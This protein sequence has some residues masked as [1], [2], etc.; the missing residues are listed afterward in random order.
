MNEIRPGLIIANPKYNINYS[1]I[2]MLGQGSFGEVWL[3]M[4]QDDK[5]HRIA[6][7]FFKPLQEGDK[8][9]FLTEY[10][11]SA[12]FRHDNVLPSLFYGEW[13][14]RLFMGMKLC[15]FGTAAQFI[16]KLYPNKKEDEALIWNFI[17]DTASGLEYLHERENVVHQDIK[18]DNVMINSNGDFVIMDFGISVSVN[19]D[20]QLSSYSAFGS[21]AYMAPERFTDSNNIIY[22]NDIWSLGVSI[23]EIVVGTL[24][25][26]GFGG[27]FAGKDLPSLPVGWSRQLNK[28]MQSCFVHQTWLRKR[29]G[30][31]KQYAEWVLKGRKGSDPWASYAPQPPESHLDNAQN[32]QSNHPHNSVKGKA[33]QRHVSEIKGKD[34]IR[35]DSSTDE[36]CNNSNQDNDNH[37]NPQNDV[38]IGA[39]GKIGN[40]VKGLFNQ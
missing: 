3:A 36:S 28:V 5:H 14:N 16:G 2:R 30:E 19:S 13:N 26:N 8:N 38:S 23:Y 11:R 10:Q 39:L 40:W 25:F 9:L 22:A 35:N 18:P 24:P 31:I 34:T 12:N 20:I 37:A 32:K 6:I 29:A 27:E 4:K 15:E 33:T 17:Y 7:K 21:P 1:L